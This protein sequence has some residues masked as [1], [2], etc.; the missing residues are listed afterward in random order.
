MYL[1]LHTY[2][3]IHTHIYIY[4]YMNIK[5]PVITNKVFIDI[6]IANYTEESTGTNKGADGSG[7]MVLGTHIYIYIYIYMCVYVCEYMY[8]FIYVCFVCDC[9]Y[10][11]IYVYTEESTGTNKGADGSGHMVLGTMLL[12]MLRIV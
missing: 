12:L 1:Y 11:N 2:I 10:V 3:Y 7:Q 5:D 9:L 4:I 8:I 6:K